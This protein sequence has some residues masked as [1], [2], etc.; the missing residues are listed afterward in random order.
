MTELKISDP[1]TVSDEL[2]PEYRFDY[3][4]ARPNRFAPSASATKTVH[5]DP[6]VAAVFMTEETV[7]TVLRALIQ[8][9]PQ[10][11]HRDPV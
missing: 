3:S 5:L 9:M 8:A 6:D 4:Q 1:D 10:P 7:N 11:L 2:L